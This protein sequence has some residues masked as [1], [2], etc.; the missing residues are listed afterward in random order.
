MTYQ[1]ENT[2][3]EISLTNGI[4]AAAELFISTQEERYLTYLSSHPRRLRFRGGES[5]TGYMSALGTLSLLRFPDRV[6]AEVY[7]QL[8][9]EL[10]G[11]ADSLV[12]FSTTNAYGQPLSE[13]H[14]GSNSDVLNAAMLV[15]AAQQLAPRPEYLRFVRS[16][17]DYVLGKNAVGFC[18]LTGFGSQSPL[19]IHHRP[20]AADGVLLPVPGLLSG[21]PNAKQQD[22]PAVKYPPQVAAMQSWADQKESYASN[23]IC[24]NWNAPLTYI[25]G[26]LEATNAK[27]GGL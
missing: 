27:K 21:G 9:G 3:T 22:A 1:L 8:K 24:L 18:F 7:N 10:T 25:L 16:C 4:W 14:W 13:F 5:W 20:S 17:A 2:E 23:E 15:A 11:L 6:P 12:L 26:W 19:H